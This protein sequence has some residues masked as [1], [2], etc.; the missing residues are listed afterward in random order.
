MNR[1]L[2]VANDSAAPEIIGAQLEQIGGFRAT[3]VHTVRE[4]I[5]RT[6]SDQARFDA[7][8]LIT[9]HSND[10]P[11]AMC[12]RLSQAMLGAPIIILSHQA[13]ESDVVEA[14][15]AGA[16]DFVVA[17]YRPVE[18]QARMR[19]QIR[20]HANSA[21]V[22]LAIGP[23]RFHPAGRV[24]EDSH[25]GTIRLTQKETEVLKY[26]Y[27]AGGRPVARQT[28]LREVWGYKHGADSYTV[29]SHIYRLRRKIEADPTRPRFLLNEDGG[30][31]LIAMPARPWAPTGLPLAG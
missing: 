16:S 20:A 6:R 14:L 28:L 25:R 23:Y 4:A 29:E 18:L 22:V 27:R 26:L 11:T 21:H 8:L 15:E 17:P 12:S 2:I 13:G 19:A 3:I 1:L 30:Y 24:L 31:A 5:D 9:G 10:D 7:V